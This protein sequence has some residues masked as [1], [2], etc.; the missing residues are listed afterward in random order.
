VKKILRKLL[1]A[2]LLPG[3]W[4][5][6]LNV[7]RLVRVLPLKI[8]PVDPPGRVLVVNITE[9][10]GD[11]VMMMPVLERLHELLPAAQI[12]VITSAA[13]APLLRQIPCLTEIKGIGVRASRIPVWGIYR[14]LA[15]MASFVR[16]TVREPYD[17]CI[18]PRWGP[19]PELSVFLASMTS[20]SRLVGHD[21]DQEAGQSNPFNGT[22]SLLTVACKG[23]FGLPEAVREMLLLP[24]AGIGGELDPV[25]EEKQRVAALQQIADR[26][27]AEVVN[28]RFRIA[29]PYAVLAPG[30]SQP[31]RRWPAERFAVF[32]ADLHQRL[33]INLLILGGP[34]DAQIARA[35]KA[36]AGYHTLDLVGITSLPET[37]AL[38]SQ[39]SLLLAN[40][41]G[42]AHIGAGLGVPTIVLSA[43]PCTNT[44]EHANSPRRVRPVGPSVVVM[45]PAPRAPEC[46]ERCQSK[47]PHCIL[48]I[49][50]EA[51]TSQANHLLARSC[52]EEA[53]E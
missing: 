8:T 14:R 36:G 50:V 16:F 1:F 47:E 2:P 19:D 35:I 11:T 17:L 37:I 42:P 7:L 18:L 4:M 44:S 5:L 40:D 20:A 26:V 29:R 48:D 51:V 39:A 27:A 23:G 46:V 49:T 41:S 30:A 3:P 43:C 53:F 31:G 22:A 13:M 6:I 21:P 38:I 28:E 12:N 32:A 15:Q 10:L 9:F 33:G 52:Y 34:G 45:Q 24:C 25:A